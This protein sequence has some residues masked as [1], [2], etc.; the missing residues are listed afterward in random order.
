MNFI[1]P[2]DPHLDV[3]KSFLNR[4]KIKVRRRYD[5]LPKAFDIFSR[6]LILWLGT[7]YGFLLA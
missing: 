6:L 7:M 1:N 5:R 2:D 4:D 3:I